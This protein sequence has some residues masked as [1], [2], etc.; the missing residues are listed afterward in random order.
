MNGRVY[1]YRLGRFLS[2][3]PII[4]NPLSSQSINPYSY[5]GNNPLSGVDPTGYESNCV[6]TTGSH[7]C[8][9]PQSVSFA[10]QEQAATGSARLGLN[11]NGSQSQSAVT[12]NVPHDQV[13]SPTQDGSKAKDDAATIPVPNEGGGIRDVPRQQY[14]EN[15][16]LSAEIDLQLRALDAFRSDD[17]A[18]RDAA[19]L[20]EVY[21]HRWEEVIAQQMEEMRRW[22]GP[23]VISTI[24]PWEAAQAI[25][26]TY[27]L[28]RGGFALAR[29]LLFAEGE[30]ADAANWAT[31]PNR[32]YSAQELFRSAE[33]AGRFGRGPYH[34]FP[35]SFDEEIFNQGTRTVTPNF[36]QS[37]RRIL[38]TA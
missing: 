25:A 30:V 6:M 1:D 35:G 16:R 13:E 12:P 32:I 4:S 8:N 10:A 9:A 19:T 15:L 37:Y 38:V 7:I 33:E 27:A 18:P 2:V 11:Y 36:Y 22:E 29:G 5:I 34:N 23:G 17:L 20:T 3:D 26:D 14:L 24:A 31:Q 21:F 28:L